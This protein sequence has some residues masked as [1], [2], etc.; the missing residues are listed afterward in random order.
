MSGLLQRLAARATGSAWALRSDARLPFAGALPG[1]ADMVDLAQ[2]PHM[3]VAPSSLVDVRGMGVPPHA[4]PPATEAARDPAPITAQAPHPPATPGQAAATAMP[5]WLHA[6]RATIGK[7]ADPVEHPIPNHAPHATPTQEARLGTSPPRATRSAA[8]ADPPPLLPSRRADGSTAT[9][10]AT[11]R[12]AAAIAMPRPPHALPALRQSAT[13]AAHPA[14]ATEVHVHIGR[15]EVTAVA[16]P[17]P[18]QRPARERTQ[19]MSLDA[20]LQQR[21]E[22]S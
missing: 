7:A 11:A 18:A 8:D 6:P 16:A 17:Q 10:P 4:E 14:E 21:K 22:P 9:Q 3:P 12:A 13:S 1:A 19:P 2:S 15:I 5:P 20:Y